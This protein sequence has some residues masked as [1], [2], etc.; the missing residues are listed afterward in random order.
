MTWRTGPKF[1]R[2]NWL[3]DLSS[4][5]DAATTGPFA[6]PCGAVDHGCGLGGAGESDAGEQRG[7]GQ[8]SA[9]APALTRCELD[10]ILGDAR[11]VHQLDRERAN[12]RRLPGRLGDYG[13]ARRERGRGQTGE[14]RQREIPWGNTGEYPAAVQAKLVLLAGWAGQRQRPGKLPARLGGV[15]AQE[16]DRL[17]HFEHRAD[18]GLP[19]FARAEREEFLAVLLIEIGGAV[20]QLRAG[21]AAERVPADLGGLA[22]A[23]HAVDFG[24][25]ARAK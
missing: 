10:D 18:Q 13:I 7:R 23:G 22:S 6:C 3:S 19:G 17:A 24:G 16:I 5:G 20:E 8:L 1:S 14:D 2:F 25:E 21:F 4:Y 15:K 12:Q 9:D 11:L